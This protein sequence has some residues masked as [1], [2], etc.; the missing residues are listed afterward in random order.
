MAQKTFVK[1]DGRLYKVIISYSLNS[2]N[3]KIYAKNRVGQKVEVINDSPNIYWERVNRNTVSFTI[4]TKSFN[5]TVEV[6]RHIEDNIHFMYSINFNVE[7][8]Y[9]SKEIYIILG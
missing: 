4:S 1:I 6:L 7:D 8:K 9:V 2:M 3:V 5:T